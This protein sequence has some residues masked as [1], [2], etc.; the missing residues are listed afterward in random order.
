MSTTENR[1]AAFIGHITAG[2]THELRN[3]LAIIKESTGLI[4]DIVKSGDGTAPPKAEKLM[5]ATGRIEAQVKRGSDLLTN[6]NRFAHS[7]DLP[8][9]DILL[10]DAAQQLTFLCQRIARRGRHVLEV[11][12]GEQGLRLEVNLLRLQLALYTAVECCLEQLPEAGTL[13]IRPVRH[14]NRPSLEFSGDVGGEGVSFS[15]AETR[16]WSRLAAVLE[17]LGASVEEVDSA[18]GFRLTLST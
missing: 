10:D 12:A 1:E 3:V 7:L 18:Q 9:D 15:P 4:A 8:E 13:S 2:A 6:L 11:Q 5:R 16:A 14:G 17:D